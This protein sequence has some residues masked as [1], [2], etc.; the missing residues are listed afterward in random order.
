MV[1]DVT[2]AK[3]FEHLMSWKEEF[4]IQS[5]AKNPAQFPFVLLGN[6]ADTDPS[7]RQVPFRK[8]TAILVAHMTA[9]ALLRRSPK[10]KRERG[11]LPMAIYRISKPLPKMR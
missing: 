1:F 10:R 3:S 11:V 6:K 9:N 8:A 2:N 5:N 7:L 4:L